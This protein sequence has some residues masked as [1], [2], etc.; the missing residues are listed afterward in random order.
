MEGRVKTSPG[1]GDGTE[2]NIR[3]LLASGARVKDRLRT[4]ILFFQLRCS[5]PGSVVYSGTAG[6]ISAVKRVTS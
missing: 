2:M 6:C 5:A 3:R 1:D 4:F